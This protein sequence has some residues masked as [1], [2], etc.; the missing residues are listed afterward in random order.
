MQCIPWLWVCDGDVDCADG[1][2]EATELC[3][4]LSN[5]SVQA[6]FLAQVFLYTLQNN[7]HAL[8][9]VFNAIR[10]TLP[11]S[12]HH[13]FVMATCNVLMAVMKDLVV[14]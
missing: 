4:W 3:G 6:K 13:S 12:T 1:C 9:K 2:D 10:E 5:I 8:K 11:A 14:R 7:G